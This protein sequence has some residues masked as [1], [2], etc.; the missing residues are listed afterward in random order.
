MGIS[1]SPSGTMGADDWTIST[2][3]SGNNELQGP[4]LFINILL[5]SI[6]LQL[7]ALSA[8]V[9]WFMV[10]ERVAT[11]CSVALLLCLST[12]TPPHN[13]KYLQVISALF[14]VMVIPGCLINSN[15]TIVAA[16]CAISGE[17]AL[18]YLVATSHKTKRRLFLWLASTLLIV[19]GFWFRADMWLLT[20]PFFALVIICLW[21]SE[22]RSHHQSPWRAKRVLGAIAL[23]LV[24]IG[25]SYAGDAAFWNTQPE[26]HTWQEYNRARSYLSDYPVPEYDTIR[27]QLDRLSISEND[28]WLAT[29]WT[30]ASPEVFDT[31]TLKALDEIQREVE[32]PDTAQ[33]YAIHLA[34]RPHLIALLL[35]VLAIASFVVKSNGAKA[36][37]CAFA[38]LPVVI[39][40]YF[41][42]TGRL[43]SRV[44]DPVW[45]MSFAYCLLF[46]CLYTQPSAPT[47]NQ[48]GRKDSASGAKAISAP[49]KPWAQTVVANL[50]PNA[51][52]ILLSLLLV[53]WSAFAVHGLS[54]NPRSA[55]DS[56][57]I[58]QSP[59]VQYVEL[60]P[61][62]VFWWDT[63]SMEAYRDAFGSK[64]IPPRTLLAQNFKL[65][66]WTT[67][68]PQTN[69]AKNQ[70]NVSLGI[71]SLIDNEKARY[72]SLQGSAVT[73]H[74][75]VF[76]QEHYNP[77]AVAILE[78]TITNDSTGHVF[79][80]WRFV[81]ENA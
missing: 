51:S 12:K 25:M 57:D 34:S 18:V 19:F 67:E 22:K 63:S 30:T 7:N 52:L 58:K 39:N 61:G 40:S 74:L 70:A 62:N 29:H 60:N 55:K 78:L 1:L 54:F 56:L 41:W 33:P 71:G 16:C 38:I 11:F 66:G 23:P 45:A 15:F 14:L 43:P 75:L 49:N 3:L 64:G 13:A 53:S 32:S 69:N 42:D 9:N 76:L 4:C 59:I 37:I 8:G 17:L 79:E 48:G 26:W 46:M 77:S 31:A 2:I 20:T 21:L 73:D 47:Q 28:W 65:G 81:A 6:I 35:C 24:I 27:A 80:V 44:E 36:V 50:S 68:S 72:I 5:S 10:V